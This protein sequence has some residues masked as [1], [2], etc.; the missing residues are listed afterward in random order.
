MMGD[1]S[2]ENEPSSIQSSG[3][4]DMQAEA[5]SELLARKRRK[6]TS[7]CAGLDMSDVVQ[8]FPTVEAVPVHLQKCEYELISPM[9]N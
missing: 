2:S 5:G 4:H 3:I 9:S 6:I 7:L 1:Q 8:Q